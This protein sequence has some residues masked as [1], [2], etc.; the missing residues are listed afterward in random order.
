MIDSLIPSICTV[1]VLYFGPISAMIAS[2][3]VR[4][5]IVSKDDGKK[6]MLPHP[7]RPWVIPSGY[8][9][10]ADEAFRAFRAFENSKEWGFMFVPLLWIFYFYVSSIPL[11]SAEWGGLITLVVAILYVCGD[12]VYIRGYLESA[13]GR[14]RGFVIRTVAF[15]IVGF[16]HGNLCESL[17]HLHP[18]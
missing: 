12:Q 15:R 2:S 17:M 18:W 3:K 5:S 13:D 7:Y 8:E 9:S 11:V 6:K 1:L 10:G 4:Y 16:S 14:L